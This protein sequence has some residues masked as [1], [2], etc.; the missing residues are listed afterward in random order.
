MY[1]IQ[2]I[3]A[4]FFIFLLLLFPERLRFKFGDFLG[5]I[6]YK[7]I[8]S[9]R[10]TALINLRMAF[11]EKSEE[12]IEKIAKKSFKIMIKAFLCSLWFDKYLND[13]KNIKIVNQE[14][15]ENAYKKGRGV[16]AATMHMGNMEASTVCTGEHKIITVAKKQRNPYIND[17]IRKL[18]GKADYMEVIEK[19]ERTS[20]VLISKLKEKKIYALFSDH[21]DKGAIVNFFG[22]E[23]K[24]PSGAI[25]MALKFD[26]PFVLVY[27]TFNEDNT[28]TVYVTDEIELKRTD[29]FK[30]DVQNNVQYLI[31]I[32]EDVIRKYPEQWMW[33]HDRWNSFREYKKDLKN[34]ERRK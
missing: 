16:M 25:S 8:K 19:N 6:A 24:A 30:E 15:M 1:Y 29:N 31:N 4:R 23:T 11:P 26:M 7:L 13:P 22:K 2:Y 28:I 27:N 17:Y 14:S 20:R 10:L 32:M 3:I 18:R 33:F 5:M 34:K 12:E 21:R 9:R